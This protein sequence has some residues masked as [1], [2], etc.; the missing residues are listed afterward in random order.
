MNQNQTNNNIVNNSI[1]NNAYNNQSTIQYQQSVN[2][3]IDNNRMKQNN[4]NKNK[5]KKSIFTI[6]LI[7]VIIGLSVYIYYTDTM[8]KNQINEI[9]YSCT[10][11]ASQSELTQLNIESDTVKKLYSIIS[12]NIEE[13]LADNQL[14]EQMK[15]YL[16]LRQVPNNKINNRSN[17]N[18]FNITSMIPYTCDDKVFTPR[19]IKEEDLMLEVRKLF[20]ESTIIQNQNIHPGYCVGG[21]QYIKERGEYVEGIC[22]RPSVVS[23]NVNKT[24]IK[25]TTQQGY[26]KLYE[27]VEYRYINQDDKE[28]LKSGTYVYTFK[29]DKNYNFIYLSKEYEVL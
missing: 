3:Q 2:T 18:L 14:D 9:K 23:A 20:G 10:P 1:Q 11:L 16:A 15:L 13:D 19:A 4:T 8:Y 17:C 26:I 21:Y 27:K 7:F 24:L 12:T 6:L 5:S 28:R 25:A 22:S 29:L